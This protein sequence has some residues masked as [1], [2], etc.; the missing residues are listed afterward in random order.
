MP[1]QTGKACNV[2]T[3]LHRSI[4][5]ADLC[6]HIAEN[7]LANNHGHHTLEEVQQKGK[8][9]GFFAHRTEHI[10]ST[11]VSAAI[12]TDVF[13]VFKDTGEDDG[14][15]QASQEIRDDCRADSRQDEVR[16][17]TEIH[18]QSLLQY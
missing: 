9:G 6:G 1:Q 5:H 4:S 17:M 11:G 14:E 3:I 13:V 8:G 15:A 7:Q 2:R 16:K 12:R 10:G 18:G